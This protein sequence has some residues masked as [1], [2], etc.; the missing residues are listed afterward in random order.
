MYFNQHNRLIPISRIITQFFFKKNK[1]L[2]ENNVCWKANIYSNRIFACILQFNAL[3]F[4]IERNIFVQ[5]NWI[6]VS[7]VFFLSCSIKARNALI[8][9]RFG[10]SEISSNKSR[11]QF[12]FEIVRLKSYRHFFVKMNGRRTYRNQFS[13][14]LNPK[15]NIKNTATDQQNKLWTFYLYLKDFVKFP[16]RLFYF[17]NNSSLH[18]VRFLDNRYGMID[19]CVYFF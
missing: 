3:E 1:N 9:I 7:L 17:I 8:M 18:G 11:D 12:Q 16:K 19:R 4:A 2:D 15:I 14:Q 13:L 6:L 10:T 5:L